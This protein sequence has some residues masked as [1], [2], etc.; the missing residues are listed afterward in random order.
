[1]GMAWWVLCVRVELNYSIF[2]FHFSTHALQVVERD[3]NSWD[4][5]PRTVSEHIQVYRENLVKPAEPE[6]VDEV[7]QLDLFAELQPQIVKQQKFYLNQGG[8]NNQENSNF[9]RLTA[10]VDA[11]IPISVSS[12]DG[13]HHSVE[14]YKFNYIKLLLCLFFLFYCRTSSKTGR[15]SR[16]ARDQMDGIMTLTIRTQRNFYVRRKRKCERSRRISTT[17]LD[18]ETLIVLFTFIHYSTI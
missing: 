11:E 15:T 2:T 6:P 10:G 7:E 3:W 9:S 17:T 14:C 12:V 18:E 13:L 4:D 8:V 16:V 1:M 5:S